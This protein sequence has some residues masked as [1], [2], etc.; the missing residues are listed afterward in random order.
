MSWAW[1]Y[2]NGARAGL[3]RSEVE[4]LPLGR[5]YDQVACW[6]ISACGAKEKTH[7]VGGSLF[8]QTQ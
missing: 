7:S 6:M 4:Y 1:L 2:Y 5:V 8:D 3:T